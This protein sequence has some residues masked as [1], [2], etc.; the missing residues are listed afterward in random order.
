[1]AWSHAILED[2]GGMWRVEVT[3]EDGEMLPIARQVT[4]I[5]ADTL[6]A[7][8]ATESETSRRPI[9]TVIRDP[10]FMAAT[11]IVVKRLRD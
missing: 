6:I 5:Q 10:Y 3:D 9:K 7:R 4:R 8:I 11:V 2:A 1:L